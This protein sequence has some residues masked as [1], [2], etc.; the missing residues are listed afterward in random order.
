MSNIQDNYIDLVRF[1]GIFL[2][3]WEHLNPFQDD[4]YIIKKAIYTFHMPLFFILSGF[5]T[6]DTLMDKSKTNVSFTFLSNEVNKL[7]ISYLL[8]NIIALYRVGNIVRTLV[9]FPQSNTQHGSLM[10]YLKRELQIILFRRKRS[11]FYG[12]FVFKS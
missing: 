8:Y 7:V 3:I 10:P 9:V 1:I 12:L 11:R 5:L 4:N 2:V 6:K